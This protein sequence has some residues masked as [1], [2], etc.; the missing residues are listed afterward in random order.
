MSSSPARL[1]D[2]YEE[3]SRS[4]RKLSLYVFGDTTGIFLFLSS[5]FF[6]MSVWR[7][8]FFI[9]DNYTV[10]NAVVGVSEGHLHVT[11]V[12]YGPESGNTPGAF[13]IDGKL[14]GRNYGHVFF[15]L[16]FVLILKSLE[17]IA[18]MRIFLSGLWSL[19]LLQ[20]GVELGRI[21]KREKTV[22]GFSSIVSVALFV[23]NV[24]LATPINPKWIPFIGLQLSSM[25]G[26]GLVGVTVY[27]LL[28]EIHS[29]RVGVYAGVGVLFGSPVAFWA[30]IPKRHVITALLSVL[31]VYFFYRGSDSKLPN[32]EL[33]YR[34]LSYVS[35]GLLAWVHAPEALLLLSV[36]LPFDFL[37][38]DSNSPKHLT[39]VGTA[40]L[41]SLIP[42]F[43]TNFLISGSPLKP[44]RLLGRAG[45]GLGEASGASSGGSS[46]FGAITQLPPLSYVFSA[47]DK[48]LILSNLFVEGFHAVTQQPRRLYHTFIRS[49]RIESIDY[50]LQSQWVIDLTI[51]ESTPVLG[52]LISVPVIAIIKL[53][54][55]GLGRFD[56]SNPARQTDLFVLVYSSLF[57]LMYMSRLPVHAQITM[58]YVVPVVPLLIY[59]V[60]RIPSVSRAVEESR[61]MASST[62][63]WTYAVTVLIGGQLLFGVLVGY[64]RPALSEA[65]QLHAILNLLGAS[66]LGVWSL[67][68]TFSNRDYPR[69]GNALIGFVYGLT[70]VFLVLFWWSYSD[71]MINYEPAMPVVR[72]ISEYLG[73]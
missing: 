35:V 29:Q 31:T 50:S 66:T 51:L 56:L 12:V 36:L 1:V 43:L 69:I 37:S 41:V 49:G 57:T 33:R 47:F 18:D 60:F 9:T 15:A 3:M 63:T 39:V 65:V 44:P 48:L 21:L 30:T 27:R 67:V 73:L 10:A 40:F 45:T 16:P 70:T 68:S 2:R 54:E 58:R 46:G 24:H 42:F 61:S 34:S 53:R 64:V 7:V 32:D 17:L 26:A 62:F 14:Y 72:I 5:V 20:T 19:V 11:D 23:V 25:V 4:F 71:L 6:F 38:S 13:R 59:G 22:T 8:G 28:S 55:S 52:S